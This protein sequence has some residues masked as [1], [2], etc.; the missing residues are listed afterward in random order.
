MELFL[1]LFP[2]LLS[3]NR[4]CILF[5]PVEKRGR[6]PNTVVFRKGPSLSYTWL[7]DAGATDLKDGISNKREYYLPFWKQFGY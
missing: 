7:L 3:V 6:E 4:N 1:T 2:D 5:N